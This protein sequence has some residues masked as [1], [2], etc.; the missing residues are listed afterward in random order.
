M[1]RVAGEVAHVIKLQKKAKKKPEQTQQK[2]I[3]NE[4][5]QNKKQTTENF[6]SRGWRLVYKK[7]KK[8]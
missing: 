8:K 3:K 5:K 2:N 1:Q 4:K 7:K 6:L